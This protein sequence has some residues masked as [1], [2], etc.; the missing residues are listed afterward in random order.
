MEAK[1]KKQT[2]LSG[3]RKKIYCRF[4]LIQ[5]FSLLAS[6]SLDANMQLL[7]LYIITIINIFALEL[8]YQSGSLK[9]GIQCKW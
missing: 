4:S 5:S 9:C 6:L 1:R 7:S 8:N 3:D 2:I